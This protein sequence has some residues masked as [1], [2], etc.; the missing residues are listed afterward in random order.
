MTTVEKTTVTPSAADRIL[1]RGLSLDAFVGVH[2]FEHEKR[3]NL[4]IDIEIDTVADYASI[5]R[6]T[7]RYVSYGDAVKFATELAGS[8]R[9]IELVETWA[10]EVAE[11][12]L[13]NELAA[14]VRVT[15]LKTE[16]FE[17]AAGVGITIERRRP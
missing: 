17:Q 14:C 2:D 6:E 7:G 3:Q 8:D 13:R 16:I 10:E 15:V 9:H 5:V 11:F 4:L 1:V 12:V